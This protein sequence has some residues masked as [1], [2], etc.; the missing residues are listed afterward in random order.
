[1]GK[2]EEEEKRQRKVQREGQENPDKQ[3]AELCVLVCGLVNAG[4]IRVWSSVFVR[5]CERDV[6]LWVSSSGRDQMF[7]TDDT[8]TDDW[9]HTCWTH[10]HTPLTP[11][12]PSQSTPCLLLIPWKLFQCNCSAAASVSNLDWFWSRKRQNNCSHIS[13]WTLTGLKQL[14][15]T[16]FSI[17]HQSMSQIWSSGSFEKLYFHCSSA[18]EWSSSHIF[19]GD[20]IIHLS[21]SIALYVWIIYISS[22]LDLLLEI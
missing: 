21:I 12:N 4:R 6:V 9:S 22:Y 17:N 15:F 19:W 10:K 20:F 1:M 18:E 14:S 11:A 13:R 8:Y 16:W 2:R 3:Q 7:F 5:P